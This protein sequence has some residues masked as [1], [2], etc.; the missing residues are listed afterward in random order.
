MKNPFLIGE[1]VYLRPV[2]REDAV[3]MAKWFNS[4]EVRRSVLSHRPVSLAQ[5]EEKIASIGKDEHDVVLAIARREP[6]GLLGATGLHRIDFKNRRAEFGIAVGDPAEWGKGYGTEATRLIVGYGFDTLNLNR[7][8][9][10]VYEDNVR[11]I[12]A[13]ERAGFRRE[14]VLRQ[15]LYREGRYQDAFL[16]SVLKS[17]W[18]A[19]KQANGG[20]GR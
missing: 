5:Q 11:G 16:M 18:D 6:D 8:Q 4:W 17:D 2:E 9:L 19:A 10:L 3:L 7:I 20:G 1:R 12:R 15:Y 14:G 13:Y